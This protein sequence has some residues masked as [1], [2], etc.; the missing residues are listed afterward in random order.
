MPGDAGGFLDIR[1]SVSAPSFGDI[2][3]GVSASIPSAPTFE[4]M[5]MSSA[6]LEDLNPTQNALDL[7]NYLASFEI[8]VDADAE[9]GVPDE[10]EDE[11]GLGDEVRSDTLSHL[12]TFAGAIDIEGYGDLRMVGPGSSSKIC[13]DDDMKGTKG[14]GTKGTGTGGSHSK[15]LKL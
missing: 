8:T 10:N 3:K 12:V 11:I 4:D 15:Y 13:F 1:L 2:T 5:G 9:A 14:T 6:T 7:Y